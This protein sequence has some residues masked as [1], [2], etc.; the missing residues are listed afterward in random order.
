MGLFI[1]PD[2]DGTAKGV[3]FWD[4]GVSYGN[5][6]IVLILNFVKR[7]SKFLAL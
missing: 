2:E 6:F 4:D 3:L 7:V 1:A 5:T